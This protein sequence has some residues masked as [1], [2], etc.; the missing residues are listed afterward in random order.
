MGLLRFFSPKS[1][2]VFEEKGDRLVR[3]NDL[4]LAKLQYETALS[5]LEG[6]SLP[7]VIEHR[8]RIEMK[9]KD[10]RES[11]ALQHKVSAEELVA[12]GCFEEAGELLELAREL[13]SDPQLGRDIDALADEVVSG[14]SAV[15]D[16]ASSVEITE[17][18]VF[19]LGD[20]DAY[21]L[22]LCSTLP[23][24]V[25]EAYTD[26]G[27]DFQSGYVALNK[28]AFEAAEDLL[29]KALADQEN[30]ITYIHLEL[31]TARLNLGDTDGAR[32]LLEVFIETYPDSLR[33][34]EMLCEIYWDAGDYDLANGFLQACPDTL[35]TS[36]SILLLMGETLFRSGDAEAETEP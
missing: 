7:G 13:T 31:A 22:V 33:A 34:Y 6:S 35:K 10:A 4:G 19:D 21:F 24:D 14:S 3:S 1:F 20:E 27:E 30:R 18:E 15:I 26:L 9:I 29:N 23:D 16:S 28:G 32:D 2:D 11:L 5:R 25:Q 17:S 8:D 36:I 12:A